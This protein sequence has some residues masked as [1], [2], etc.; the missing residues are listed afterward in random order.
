MPTGG[1]GVAGGWGIV[2]VEGIGRL[3]VDT[4]YGGDSF[5]IVD[6][7]AMG[8]AL[9]PDEAQSK[10]E[11]Q[12]ADPATHADPTLMRRLNKR[13]AQLAPTVA[14]LLRS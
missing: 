13:Y 8:F 5:V 14:A 11:K 2:S 12:L 3:K 9:T 6:A 1:S 4:A 10:L 7:A